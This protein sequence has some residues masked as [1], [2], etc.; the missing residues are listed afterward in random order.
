[1][2]PIAVVLIPIAM[3]LNKVSSLTSVMNDFFFNTRLGALTPV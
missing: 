1:M 2:Y 3:V